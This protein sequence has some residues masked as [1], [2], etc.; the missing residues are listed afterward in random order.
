M[1]YDVL[2]LGAGAAGL[3]AASK[4][5]PAWCIAE[6]NSEPAK[7]IYATGNGRCNY[8]NIKAPA[9]ALKGTAEQLK[10]ALEALGIAGVE[11]EEGRM[12]P[13]SGR[14][15]D[16][17]C[18]L[19][20]GA[21]RCGTDFIGDF[22]AVGIVKGNDIFTVTSREGRSLQAKKLLLAS[23]GKAG[24]QYGCEGG[25]LRMAAALGHRVIKPIPALTTLLC[26]DNM[27]FIAGVRVKAKV[28]LLKGRDNMVAPVAQD[29][30]ELLF[31]KN[32]LSGICVMNLSRFYRIEEGTEYYVVA[33][34]LEEYTLDALKALL[35]ARCEAFASEDASF[36]LASI[37][38]PK[39]VDHILSQVGI[40]IGRSCGSLTER[41][42][43][44]IA[45]SCKLLRFTICGSGGWKDAQVTSGGV[46]L[47]EVDPDT[48]ESKLV[49]GLYFA[50]EILNYDGPC[51]GY[52][53]GW[54]F[55]T[56]FAAAEAMNR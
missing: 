25:G 1:L 40:G 47:S 30:G 23:G 4:G 16:V 26:E 22:D 54:A 52:N 19:I 3:A 36:L 56:G 17:A 27:A 6:K 5:N 12:Y 39:L 49:P 37:L 21:K 38:P 42:R 2:I 44:M 35:A 46:D 10:A 15:E 45:A 9:E 28:S 53:L 7:K 41:E 18:A 31:G 48:M 29:K 34:L 50:G 13:R 43:L 32:G 20:Y 8:M 11:E 33:D 24:I 51:G 55:S 14:A